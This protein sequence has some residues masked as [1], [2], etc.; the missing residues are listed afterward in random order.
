MLLKVELAAA[1]AAALFRPHMCLW[2]ADAYFMG[3]SRTLVVLQDNPR[4]MALSQEAQAQF[5]EVCAQGETDHHKIIK[6][7]GASLKAQQSP[8]DLVASFRQVMSAAAAAAAAMAGAGGGAG[9]GAGGAR[10]GGAARP[11]VPRQRADRNNSTCHI[12]GQL[13]H[14][15]QECPCAQPGFVAGA[16]AAPIGRPLLLG[17]PGQT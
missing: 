2:G 11:G 7:V 16:N 3:M 12:C 15:Q 8:E 1:S 9:A 5:E 6:C 4:V 14:W 10:V 13:G 17:P